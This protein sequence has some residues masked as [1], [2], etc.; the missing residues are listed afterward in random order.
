MSCTVL[1]GAGP[2]GQDAG[3]GRL[4]APAY[5]GDDQGGSRSAGALRRVVCGGGKDRTERSLGPGARHRGARRHAVAAHGVAQGL[6]FGGLRVLHQLREPQGPASAEPSQGGDAVSLEVAAP[7]GPARRRGVPGHRRRGRCLLRYQG[8]GQPD[9][10]LGVGP[11]A[12]AGEPVRAGEAGGGV[13]RSASGRQGAA[14]GA[15]VGLSAAARA[16]R[17]LA[18]CPFPAARPSG[19]QS[20]LPVRT[21]V[22]TNPVPLTATPDATPRLMRWASIASMSVATVLI[23]AKTAAWLVTDSVSMLSSLIDSALDLVSSLITFVAIR[24]A[25]TPADADHRFGHGKAEAL[26]GVAQAGFI[27]ASA[28]RLL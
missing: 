3:G 15:L 28:G 23:V 17:I 5:C 2:P 19:V 25:L 12:A 8:A 14:A 7:P 9:R 21:M 26:A 6:R 20:E 18:G 13:H 22:D 10:R 27:T 24:L 16:D 4:S 11:I 1:S